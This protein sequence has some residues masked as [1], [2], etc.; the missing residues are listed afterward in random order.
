VGTEQ[1]L[2]ARVRSLEQP[3]LRLRSTRD[4]GSTL[5]TELPLDADALAQVRPKQH[6]EQR[7]RNGCSERHRAAA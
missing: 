6:K 1:G 5:E 3:V 7:R 4:D 2:Y